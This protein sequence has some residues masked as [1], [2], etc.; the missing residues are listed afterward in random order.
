MSAKRIYYTAFQRSK[1]CLALPIQ[2]SLLKHRPIS[3]Q[4]GLAACVDEDNVLTRL[5][6]ALADVIDEGGHGFS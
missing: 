2:S 5:K 3:V 6:F 4:S 1:A